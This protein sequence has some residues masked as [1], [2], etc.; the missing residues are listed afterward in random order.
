MGLFP[1]LGRSPGEG[2]INSLQYAG[3]GNPMDRVAWRATFQGGHKR[4]RR[5][6]PA[7]QQVT[8]FACM[9]FLA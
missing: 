2:N 7:K 6:L 8:S 1:V 3:L 5:D 4:V 9:L